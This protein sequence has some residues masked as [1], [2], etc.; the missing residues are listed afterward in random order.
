[1]LNTITQV[2]NNYSRGLCYEEVQGL[3]ETMQQGDRACVWE[4][5]TLRLSS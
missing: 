4:R 3:H 5:L 1:M 2:I